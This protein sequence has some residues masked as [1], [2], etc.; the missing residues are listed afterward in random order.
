MMV[1]QEVV[2][3]GQSS[4]REDALARM[5]AIEPVPLVL[6]AARRAAGYDPELVGISQQLLEGVTSQVIAERAYAGYRSEVHRVGPR[7]YQ[8]PEGLI[9]DPALAE[10][11]AAFTAAG[12]LF[13]EADDAFL[14]LPLDHRL[15]L[16]GSSSI[17]RTLKLEDRL[18]L[19]TAR[20][21]VQFDPGLDE[22]DITAFCDR[23]RIVRVA[24]LGRGLGLEVLA[25]FD[26]HA[27]EAAIE[28]MDDDAVTFA[29][30]DLIEHIGARA[31]N[32]PLLSRQWHLENTGQEGGLAGADISAV[33]AWAKSTG[34]N[35]RLAVI[36]NGFDITHA[37]L[38]FSNLSGRFRMTAAGQDADF[39][40]G[41]GGMPQG[42]HGTACAGMAAARGN[43]GHGGMG[44]AWGCELM[45]IACLDDQ[46]GTQTTL[47]RAIG[48]ASDPRSELPD[49]QEG[50]G[51]DV[52]VC[53]L[54]PNSANWPL[55]QTLRT[56]IEDAAQNGRSGRGLPIFWAVTNGNFPVAAD[57][58]CSHPDV[59]AVGR[60]TRGDSDDGS[61]FGPKLEYLAPGVDVYIPAAGNAYQSTTGTSFAAP[62]AAG[63]AVL[64]L[65]TNREMV[66]DELRALM[67]DTCDRIGDLPYNGGRNDRFGHGRLNAERA[68]S[69]ALQLV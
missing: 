20:V 69:R 39:V 31:F 54:G 3:V 32:D 63:V 45:A 24:R 56:F 36:D 16:G 57:G 14:S 17:T 28:L 68:V 38:A 15:A 18:L 12:I 7:N 25:V 53:S 61:G 11:L 5:A 59:I 67:I 35:V 33:S 37:D 52:L 13:F 55:S 58:V 43:N 29:E 40:R 66:R 8:P 2:D 60:S 42:N 27:V 21:V 9:R 47:G 48:Y 62:C 41:I 1:G 19:E 51:A 22:D 23:H 44:V 49:V 10:Q 4:K 65:A 34:E 30:A 64:V 50:L 6:P 26:R 46:V